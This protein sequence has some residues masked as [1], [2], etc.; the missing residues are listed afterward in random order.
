MVFC[1]SISLAYSSTYCALG[2]SAG[3]DLNI[4]C[5]CVCVC[6]CTCA[7]ACVCVCVC[8]DMYV[9]VWGV[10]TQEGNRSAESEVIM[11]RLTHGRTSEC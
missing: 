7:C 3:V 5:V 6:V 1:L 4:L 11:S 9:K 2:C 10:V 8:V